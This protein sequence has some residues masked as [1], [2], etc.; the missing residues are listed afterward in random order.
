MAVL[1][2]HPHHMSKED[3]A[4]HLEVDLEEVDRLIERGI[5]QEVQHPVHGVR[6]I[7]ASVT[8]LDHQ[9]RQPRR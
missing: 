3:A 8:R 7:T 6:V 9:R 2:N 5:L 1:V 4:S